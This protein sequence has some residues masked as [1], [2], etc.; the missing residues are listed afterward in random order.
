M[1]DLLAKLAKD[2]PEKYATFWKEFGAVLKEGVAQDHAN[3]DK[4][5]AAAALREHPRARATSPRSA[6][7]QYVERMKP[8]Q[9]RIYYVIAESIDAARSSPYI[10]RLKERGLEVLLLAE[11]I[12]EWVMGQLDEFEGKKL[13]GR[14]ARRSGARHARERARTRSSTR[15]RHKES[16]GL[17]KRVK[18]ALGERVEEVR[19]SA[20]LK[21]SPAVPGAGRAR[22]GREHAA[23]L[24]GRRPEGARVEAGARDQRRRTR[25]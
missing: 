5:P 9:E 12:D 10:E 23:H 20:R 2:E 11:R 14:R 24:R 22:H 25:S 13:Q 16:K 15:R 21:E 3:R 18:D 8:G 6:S 1:L 4:H 17:L 7:P 19:A